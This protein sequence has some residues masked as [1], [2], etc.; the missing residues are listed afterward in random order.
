MLVELGAVLDLLELEEQREAA[1]ET[2]N[3]RN[4]PSVKAGQLHYVSEPNRGRRSWKRD[5]AAR[6]P[7]YA[8][9][10]RIRGARGKRLLRARG[11]KLERAFAHLLTTGGMRR[12]HLRGHENIRKRMLVHAAGFNLGLPMRHRYGYGTPRSLQGRRASTLRT[13]GLRVAFSVLFRPK[14]RVLGH[15]G[16]VEARISLR[17]RPGRA[18][19]T[20]RRH[21]A[22]VIF[23][24]PQRAFATAC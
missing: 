11:E 7:T 3:H 10:R 24:G 6:K 23:R 4:Q 16:P 17:R 8:N 1:P 15:P 13:G 14:S 21:F 20:V 18:G 19:A 2:I 9:R 22:E 5:R 12:T